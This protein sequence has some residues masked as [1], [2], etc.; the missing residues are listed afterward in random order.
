MDYILALLLKLHTARRLVLRRAT[1]KNQNAFRDTEDKI[2]TAWKAN[3]SVI[4]ILA[5]ILSEARA[6]TGLEQ[7]QREKRNG[8]KFSSFDSIRGW[9][10]TGNNIT[11]TLKPQTHS[12]Y[13]IQKTRC[14]MKIKWQHYMWR[15]LKRVWIMFGLYICMLWTPLQTAVSES[16]WQHRQT[17]KKQASCNVFTLP[18]VWCIDTMTGA[19]RCAWMTRWLYFIMKQSINS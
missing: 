17:R 11:D 15:V 10:H 2:S 1:S 5:L 19:W 3:I 13:I 18:S 16:T 8:G 4:F 14:S 9:S 7:H 12:S 6:V